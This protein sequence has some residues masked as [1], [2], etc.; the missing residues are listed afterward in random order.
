VLPQERSIRDQAIVDLL[1]VYRDLEGGSSARGGSGGGRDSHLLYSDGGP[2]DKTGC[3]ALDTLLLRLREE[4]PIQW[5]HLTERYLRCDV[6]AQRVRS[7]KGRI[8]KLGPYREALG[9]G[10]RPPDLL[11][12]GEVLVVVETWR[13]EVRLEKVRRGVSWLAVNFPWNDFRWQELRREM[14]A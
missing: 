3:D 10:V 2:W 4:R 5:W 14:V 8:V 13:P 7:Y 11:K 6:R 9:H 1:R 12:G